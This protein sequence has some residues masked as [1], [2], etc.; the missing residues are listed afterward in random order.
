MPLLQYFGFVGTSL[1]LLLLALNRLL[2][3]SKADSVRAD[4]DKS[5][6]RISSIEKLPDAVVYDMSLPTIL[7]PPVVIA[8]SA[9]LTQSAFAFVQITPGPLPAFSSVRNVVRTASATAEPVAAKMHGRPMIKRNLDAATNRTLPVV[10]PMV[11][12]SLIDA[13]KSGFEQSFRPN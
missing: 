4:I 11:R 9:P 3:E 7:P 8:T 10:Q 5:V 13:I 6:I 2:P 12:L 1:V